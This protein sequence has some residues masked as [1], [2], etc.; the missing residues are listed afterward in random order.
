MESE[1]LRV[2]FF[3]FFFEV[4]G[5]RLVGGSGESGED[6]QELDSDI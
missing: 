3:V 1:G 6:F 5:W 2:F 4:G